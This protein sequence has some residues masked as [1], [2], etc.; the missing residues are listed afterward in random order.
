M[1][2]YTA[3]T[4][5]ISLQIADLYK[6]MGR[7]IQSVKN[8]IELGMW[9]K[10]ECSNNRLRRREE[11][12]RPGSINSVMHQDCI[13]IITFNSVDINQS[14]EFPNFIKVDSFSSHAP[15]KQY[16]SLAELSFF[17]FESKRKKE[18]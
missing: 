7:E 9:M 5:D 13:N 1:I 2:P 11:K 17:Y 18:R 10:Q 15:L 12:R 8:C 14:R 3:N 4:A 6:G 16:V